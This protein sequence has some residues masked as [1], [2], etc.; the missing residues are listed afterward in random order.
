[1]QIK[2]CK[3]KTDGAMF[4]PSYPDD[5][6][7]ADA[8]AD[9]ADGHPKFYFRGVKWQPRKWWKIWQPRG[10]WIDTGDIWQPQSGEF[11]VI[12]IDL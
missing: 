1:M 11:T 4:R 2:L 9:A 7:V 3:R 5:Y 8:I 12:D 6:S 10:E